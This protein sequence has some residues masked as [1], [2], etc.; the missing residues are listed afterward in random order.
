MILGR[1]LSEGVKIHDVY[2][3]GEMIKSDYLHQGVFLSDSE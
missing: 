1:E 3:I 2:P